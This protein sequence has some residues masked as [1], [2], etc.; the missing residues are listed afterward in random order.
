MLPPIKDIL[1]A[2]DFSKNADYALRYALSITEGQNAK[3]HILHVAEPLSLDAMVTFNLYILDENEKKA[4]IE[5]RQEAIK[6]ALKE[7][8]K[9]FFE[10]LTNKEKQAYSSVSSAEI[11]IGHPAEVI[12][13]RAKSLNCKMIVMATHEQ[14]TNQTFLGTVAKRVLRRSSVPVLVVPPPN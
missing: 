13:Q 8:Q 9:Q 12:L 2:T 11:I 1:L 7:N 10:S 14:N 4:I 6:Q 5:K 3:V